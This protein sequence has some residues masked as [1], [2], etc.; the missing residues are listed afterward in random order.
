L[1]DTLS[2]DLRKKQNDLTGALRMLRAAHVRHP[3]ERSIAYVLVDTLLAADQAQEALRFTRDDLQAYS[4]DPR[5]HE[6]QARAYSV[7]GKRVQQH[8]AQAEAYALNG[9]LLMA[10]EQLELAQKPGDGD[11]FELSQVD[12]RLREFKQRHA[13]EVKEKKK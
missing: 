4:S 5:M 2:A 3:H 1:I 13:E 8:R 12:A 9:Q 11:Y 7:L 6:F 10:I